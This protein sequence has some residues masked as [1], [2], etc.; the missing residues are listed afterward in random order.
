ML[1]T[2]HQS[3]PPPPTPHLWPVEVVGQQQALVKQCLGHRRGGEDPEGGGGG[4][5]TARGRRAHTCMHAVTSSELGMSRLLLLLL[6]PQSACTPAKAK[7]C[8]RTPPP[9]HTPPCLLV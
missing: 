7:Q 8:S 2:R 9:S 1:V 3:P 4:D 6:L 5:T